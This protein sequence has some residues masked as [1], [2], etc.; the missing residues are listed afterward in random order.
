MTPLTFAV[1]AVILCNN[2]NYEHSPRCNEPV[3]DFTRT[4][5]GDFYGT[6]TNGIPFTQEW[7]TDEVMIFKMEKVK[8][9][10]YKDKIIY[11]D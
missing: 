1:S 10:V 3:A 8:Y 7:I 5:D 4:V 9:A 6:L 2:M 11:L